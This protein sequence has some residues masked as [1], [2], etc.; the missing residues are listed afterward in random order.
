MS[1]ETS[2]NFPS[3]SNL[4]D[5]G[6]KWDNN[7]KCFSQKEVERCTIPNKDFIVQS[8]NNFTCYKFSNVTSEK[9]NAYGS[10][11]SGMFEMQWNNKCPLLPYEKQQCSPKKRVVFSRF[12]SAELVKSFNKCQYISSKE[13]DDLAAKIKL[14]PTQV[15]IWYVV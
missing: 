6:Y 15:K 2:Y 14:T 9:R 10:T 1:Q 12:Q 7:G 5:L 13:R 4:A 11:N 8:K 3:Y